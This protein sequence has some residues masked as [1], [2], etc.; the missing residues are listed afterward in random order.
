[1]DL[2]A[3]PETTALALIGLQGHP[4]LG[5]SLELAQRM[6]GETVSPLARAWLTIALRLHGAQVPPSKVEMAR[7]P[8]IMIAALSMIDPEFFRTGA[9]T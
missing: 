1:V 6:A 2:V 8:E 5:R 4:D 9:S 3:F 7:S